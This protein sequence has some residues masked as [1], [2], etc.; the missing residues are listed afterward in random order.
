MEEN[1]SHFIIERTH[2]GAAWE[3]IG[4]VAGAGNSAVVLDYSYIDMQPYSDVNFYRIKQVDF[5]GKFDYSRTVMLN[6]MIEHATYKMKMFPN[7]AQDVV[8]L[9]W[10]GERSGVVRVLNIAGTEVQRYDVSYQ[11]QLQLNVSALTNGNYIVDYNGDG[12]E[13]SERLIVQH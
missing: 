12:G 5:D 2:D 1:N 6:S 13:L 9:S 10:N 7:P 3:E 11:S 4:E 8:T